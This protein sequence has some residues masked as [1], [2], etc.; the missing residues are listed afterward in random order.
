MATNENDT[1]NRRRERIQ[2]IRDAMSQSMGVE[3]G[4]LPPQAVELEEAVLGAM[5][6]EQGAVN[7]VIDIL[8]P[9]SFYKETHGHI[10]EAVM[11]LFQKGEPI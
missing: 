11:N 5:M 8:K 7:T 1:R 4:K 9:A 2:G 6:L 3:L 10:Y